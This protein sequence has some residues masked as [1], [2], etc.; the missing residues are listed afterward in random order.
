MKP[1]KSYTL[2]KAEGFK[3]LMLENDYFKRRE[4]KQHKVKRK[5]FVAAP[6]F[7]LNCDSK[8]WAL[9]K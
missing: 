4:K 8:T 9:K 7:C 3:N 6:V 5:L 2:I 1:D